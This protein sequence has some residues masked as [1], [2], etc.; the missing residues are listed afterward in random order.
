MSLVVEQFAQGSAGWAAAAK[1]TLDCNPDLRIRW[2]ER[3]ASRLLHVDQVRAA[4][5]GNLRF[6]RAPHADEQARTE[7]PLSPGGRGVGS[8]GLN[9]RHDAAS[10]SRRDPFRSR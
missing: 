2:A 4:G 8:E 1:D 5:Q 6:L 3:T 7:S 10:A 9:C